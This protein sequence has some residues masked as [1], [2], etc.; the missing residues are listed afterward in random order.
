MVHVVQSVVLACNQC[1][2]QMLVSC[3]KHA[4]YRERNGGSFALSGTRNIPGYSCAV[5]DTKPS[6]RIVDLV[7]KWVY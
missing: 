3:S 5:H 2:P 7:M 6:A 4:S 1:K